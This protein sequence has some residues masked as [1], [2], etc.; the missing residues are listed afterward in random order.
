MA[1][2]I[3]IHIGKKTA[4][5]RTQDTLGTGTLKYRVAKRGG[6]MWGAGTK[7]KI[8]RSVG[9]GL[10]QIELPDGDMERVGRSSIDN[11]ESVVKDRRTK[12]MPPTVFFEGSREDFIKIVK[13]IFPESIISETASGIRAI[14]NR[15]TVGTISILK[16]G[17]WRGGYR[18]AL[19]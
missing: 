14:V 17:K 15:E 10:F 5:R 11:Y 13:S 4:D 1:K 6:G 12:D 2:H 8:L 7:V 19:R 16:N 18:K 9:S 3:H